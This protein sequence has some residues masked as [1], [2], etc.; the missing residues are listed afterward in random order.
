MWQDL[1]SGFDQFRPHTMTL[2]WA[3]FPRK[4]TD[5]K[6]FGRTDSASRAQFER[7]LE[8]TVRLLYNTPS[9]ALWTLFH[10]GWGQFDALR[11]TEQLCTLDPTRPIDHASGWHDQGG[12]DVQS[13]HAVG[14]T[15]KPK[16]D[17]QRVLALTELGGGEVT[18]LYARQVLPY[19][20]KE[21]LSAAIFHQ[22]CDVEDD[23][24]GLVTYDRQ[25][26]KADA[27]ALRALAE[28]LNFQK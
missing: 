11:L 24:T 4:D 17:G 19:I 20:E 22:W 3:K 9:L 8:D 16:S 12:G 27:T 6:A 15:V 2:P 14:R 25:R 28:Q 13:L 23:Q 7:D 18:A 1:P 5:Y 10:E 21:G 26:C